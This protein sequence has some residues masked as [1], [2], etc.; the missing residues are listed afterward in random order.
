FN[1]AGG[2][3]EACRGEGAETVEMQFLA[4]VSFS[5][6]E[7]GGRRFVGPIL[8]V[9]LE[10]TNVAELL[11]LS[12]DVALERFKA[13]PDVV[14]ALRPLVEVG[15]GYLR[16]GQP[17]SALSGGEAQRLKL[18]A[19][20]SSAGKNALIVLDEPTAGL[21]GSDVEPL[22]AC[23]ERL[24][25]AGNTVVVIEHDM[26]TAARADHVIDMGPG[27]GAAGGMIVAEGSPEEVAA[28]AESVTASHLRAVLSGA[29]PVEERTRSGQPRA[30]ANT[31][32]VRGARE[33]NLKNVDVDIPRDELV[34]VTG[35]SGSG[36]STLA[37][38][39]VFAES[40][41][42]YLETLSPYVR[43]YLKQLP[44]PQVDRVDGVP[45]GVSLEQRQ[46]AG[47]K[48]STV[49]TVTEVAHHLRLLYARVGL[50]SCPTCAIPIAPRPLEALFA[51][52]SARHRGAEID[53]LA[54][55]IRGQKGAHRELLAR[56]YTDG[57][58][59]ARVDG[60]LR[61][62]EPGM[63]LDRYREHHIELLLGSARAGTPELRDLLAR[64]LRA[65][66]G[67]ARI[68][69]GR[70]ELLLSSERAC[71][72]CGTGYPEL[73]PRFFSFNTKQGACAECEGA[74]YA[75]LES[76]KRTAEPV[77]VVC[78]SCGGRRL[79]GLALHTRVD[80]ALITDLLE[81]SVDDAHQRISN[82][83][84]AG[85]ELE[86][87][88]LPLREIATRLQFL[89]R[90]G[91]GYLAL[92]RPAWTLSG[93]EMQRVR[94]AGQLGSGLT[95]VLYVLD[96]P[97]I[98]L[99]PRDTARLLAALRELVA[100]GCSVLV[101]EHDAD[102]IRA[103]DHV[104][105]VGPV[106]GQQ[107]GYI[108]AAGSPQ[109]LLADPSSV[110]GRSL[111]RP[112]IL[113]AQ[114]RPVG[115]G[116]FIELV[117]AR[118]HNLKDVRLRVP[119]GRLCA[120]TGVSGSGKSTLVREV[121]LRAVRAELGLATDEP[122]AHDR[123]LGARGVKRAV[124]VDQSPIGRT[125]RSVPATYVGVW[126]EIR[127]LFASTAEARARGYG[128][129]RFSFNVA[130]GRCPECEGQGSLNVEMSFLPD[131]QLLCE[132]CGGMRYDP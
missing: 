42:R 20:I 74:G 49:A 105:D 112:P 30:A 120:V 116:A 48:N 24:V 2:R 72:K 100:E 54:P 14:A 88:A 17:L 8:D 66:G 79:S 117:G 103:A 110:T 28:S 84:L 118:E 65:A 97:T 41:R 52:V 92:D 18:A 127:R 114:R 106:G 90:V 23:L 62:L 132:E 3:C 87:G 119:L 64:A 1:V 115:K 4:D 11:E 91:L 125:P 7:C 35:P 70:N 44:Q 104:I 10:S 126:D 51:D 53:V 29:V 86:I 76:R 85:R 82:I 40:Q 27:A 16:L 15:A 96:E 58:R 34:V 131:A 6:P 63:S 25:D 5:C 33:H 36:K 9:K 124:E 32:A 26:R 123:V 122:G 77:R 75:E 98:G 81:R 22:L 55:V 95:G 69:T 78:A 108:V 46:T 71:P 129:S 101:V 107:G 94:L 67:S 12:A 61:E 45:P 68:M 59:R 13:M 21:H 47:A 56:A 57:V 102:T 99:H 31:I 128:A 43:Q 73:D 93:G 38:D 83:V 109:A 89:Q 19:A 37:F 80:G 60:R 121:L 113:P 111:A 39:V 50:L 130:K